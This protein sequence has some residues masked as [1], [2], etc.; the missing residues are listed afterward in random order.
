M[1][2]SRTYFALLQR[3]EVLVGV[4]RVFR[5]P[6]LRF[7]PLLALSRLNTQLF[8]RRKKMKNYVQK[9]FTLIELMIVVAIV[10]ILAAIA[11]PAYNDYVG[12]SYVA[13][14]ASVAQGYKTA[15]AEYYAIEAVY[16]SALTDINMVT[17]DTGAQG[18]V[19]S[20]A[21]GNADGV[22]TVTMS[23]I[24]PF[25]GTEVLVYTPTASTGGIIWDC[26]GADTTIDDKY[27][28]ASCK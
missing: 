12:R 1:R 10:G 15:V 3:R 24:G 2:V 8:R 20:V 13:E 5:S 11:L 19:D 16:P 18:A 6:C 4:A 17:L 27:L 14:A 28:P 21:I 9:G 25:A 22:I 23:S 7:G 26:A